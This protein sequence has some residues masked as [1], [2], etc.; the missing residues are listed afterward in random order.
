MDYNLL[1]GIKLRV[2]EDR[3]MVGLMHFMEIIHVEL[4]D[5]GGGAVVTVVP[6]KDMFF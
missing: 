3:T 6:G 2:K 1:L 5:E 4:P